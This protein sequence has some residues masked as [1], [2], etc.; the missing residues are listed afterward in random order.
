MREAVAHDE[1]T[2]AELGY[3]SPRMTDRARAVSIAVAP[4]VVSE[5]VDGEAVLLDLRNG[6]Y[7]SLNRVGTRIWQL[8][9][10]HGALEPVREQLLA[11]FE[12]SGEALERD[13]THWLSELRGRGLLVR[14]E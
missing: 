14:A 12:V 3:N 6:V 8:I 5:I 9:Q 4:D 2:P 11:E 1:R 10:Q 13:L 7:F